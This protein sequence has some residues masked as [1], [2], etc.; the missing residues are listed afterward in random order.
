MKKNVNRKKIDGILLQTNLYKRKSSL[1]PK[2]N[3]LTNNIFLSSVFKTNKTIQKYIDDRLNSLK[4]DN[5]NSNNNKINTKN[6]SLSNKAR[7]SN[8][9][10]SKIIKKS[11]KIVHIG[12]NKKLFSSLNEYKTTTHNNNHCSTN[13]LYNYL[14]TKNKDIQNKKILSP[15]Q[16]KGKKLN[17]LYSSNNNFNSSLS[18]G[19]TNKKN[20]DELL[21]TCS[22]FYISNNN[23]NNKKNVSINNN[24]EI[25]SSMDNDNKIF[26][27]GNCNGS[28]ITFGNSFSYTNSKGKNDNKEEE[29]EKI[30]YLQNQNENLK[31]ELK[32]SNKQIIHLKNEIQKLMGQKSGILSRKIKKVKIKDPRTSFKNRS[33]NYSCLD[34]KNNNRESEKIEIKHRHYSI[35]RK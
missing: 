15:T 6:S 23:E 9:T 4:T 10:K 33:K 28:I 19:V 21:K 17:N 16:I 24:Y 27:K 13:N 11:K 12:R 1:M 20:E 14:Y 7:K 34:I 8:L 26:L 2:S 30:I 22:S 31:K 32:E 29:S 25:D 35:T 5:Y 3:C 18:T